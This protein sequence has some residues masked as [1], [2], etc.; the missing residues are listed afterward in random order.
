M[1]N[2]IP[3]H[4]LFT[5]HVVGAYNAPRTDKYEDLFR[6][7]FPKIVEDRERYPILIPPEWKPKS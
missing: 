4:Q 7:E 3:K 6:R 2:L 1:E 5:P